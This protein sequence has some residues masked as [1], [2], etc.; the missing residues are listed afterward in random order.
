MSKS[1]VDTNYDDLGAFMLEL[2]FREDQHIEFI[3]PRSGDALFD[4]YG[5]TFL[6]THGDRI[7][8]RGG[9]GFVGP[10][11]T[12][13]RGFQ[14][15]SMDY[16]GGLDHILVG[17]FHTPMVLDRGLV[18][19][20]L[21]GKSEYAR[22]LRLHCSRPSQWY[23]TVHPTRGITQYREIYVGDPSEGSQCA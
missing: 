19:G 3:T 12:V 13:A 18:N 4:I 23:F 17:H 9:A 11:A 14:K 10:S 2:H 16:D 8:S 6:L 15:V 21:V 22:D 7:G 5:R 1:Y 20:S